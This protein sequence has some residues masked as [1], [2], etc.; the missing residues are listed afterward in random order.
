[1]IKKSFFLCV[2]IL[3]PHVIFAAGSAGTV[4][5][6][7]LRIY[8][9]ARP[10]AMAGAFVAI[11][12]DLNSLYF[13]PAGIA[14]IN[15]R[16]GSF[17]YVNHVLDIAS[18]FIGFVNPN[19]GPG[20]AAI[21]IHYMDYG[22]FDKTDIDGQSIGTFGASSISIA[23]NYAVKFEKGI[24]VG[25]N[26]KYIR[27]SIDNWAADAFAIDAG[28]LYHTPI[29]D[30]DVGISLTNLGQTT[31]A[32]IQT[33]DPLPLCLRLGLSKQLE[34]LPLLV[35]LSFYKYS[36]YDWHFALGGEFTLTE[37]L[38]FR[39]GY[40]QLGRELHVDSAKDR[41]AGL[42]L[43]FGIFWRKVRFDYS[44]SSIGIAGSLNRVSVSGSF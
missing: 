38:F 15:L 21:G 3:I 10:S 14:D 27:S 17:S 31:S 37:N 40:D 1:M 43:G 7:F 6:E 8:P 4:G 9:S 44:Y 29:K 20:N 42:S 34:H 5:F 16:S 35:G 2:V 36:D 19:F 28:A 30:M 33:K 41:F 22:D 18:G 23:F 26:L 12:G 25:G 11:P 13:N 39:L 32:F 24:L